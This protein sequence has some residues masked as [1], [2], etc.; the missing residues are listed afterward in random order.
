M[1]KTL[2]FGMLFI[3]VTCFAQSNDVRGKESKNDTEKKQY[4]HLSIDDS[5]SLHLL[6]KAAN[7]WFHK[8]G[9]QN[10]VREYNVAYEI[11]LD[12]VKNDGFLTNSHFLRQGGLPGSNEISTLNPPYT[13]KV[14]KVDNNGTDTFKILVTLGQKSPVLPPPLIPHC[15]MYATFY[16]DG[17]IS[18]WNW[19]L[20]PS[21]AP[22]PAPIASTACADISATDLNRAA[23]NVMI[24]WNTYSAPSPQPASSFRPECSI[25]N[26]LPPFAQQ[27]GND[28]VDAYHCIYRA[29]SPPPT[30]DYCDGRL[31]IAR[32]S[33]PASIVNLGRRLT[34]CNPTQEAYF[35][36]RSIAEITTMG[37]TTANPPQCRQQSS[38]LINC[39]AEEAGGGG[40]GP[41]GPTGNDTRCDVFVYDQ[42][43]NYP[44]VPTYTWTD[45]DCTGMYDSTTSILDWLQFDNFLHNEF[46]R[47]SNNNVD[48]TVVI[49][50]EFCEYHFD[51]NG[52]LGNQFDDEIYYNCD[53]TDKR[54]EFVRDY[55]L[56]NSDQRLDDCSEYTGSLLREEEKHKANC[57]L[58]NDPLEINLSG[59]IK[60]SSYTHGPYDVETS[61]F[62]DMNII[63][64][65]SSTNQGRVLE[66]RVTTSS[67]GNTDVI[68]PS[69]WITIGGGKTFTDLINA[70][71]RYELNYTLTSSP[72][73]NGTISCNANVS[74]PVNL[75]T[76]SLGF[77]AHLD[78]DWANHDTANGECV[79]SGVITEYHEG[80]QTGRTVS[81]VFELEADYSSN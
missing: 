73:T 46:G 77:E 3:S 18:T 66:H 57:I 31:T 47:D 29:V 65:Q 12:E 79:Y 75:N 15:F 37:I 16:R 40:G 14:M 35:L 43:G 42:E 64:V 34:T 2:F 13:V 20:L 68:N 10:R 19:H 50:N 53:N 9:H 27:P 69:P 33:G 28:W 70:G 58:Q 39:T 23:N 56:I 76:Q 26:S 52:Q 51:N 32:N 72:A 11:P 81:I 63:P 41:G 71:Y 49:S 24:Y 61:I 67:G 1:K 22:N 36:G 62:V 5:E 21:I 60:R 55:N 45:R 78:I 80:S 59:G 48:T 44:P 30:V 38:R 25:V 7:D 74:S 4:N 17:A 8:N 6:A 54:R